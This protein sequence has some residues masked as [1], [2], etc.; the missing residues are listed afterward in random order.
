MNTWAIG[1]SRTS[2]KDVLQKELFGTANAKMSDEL[3]TGTIPRDDIHFETLVRDG[4]VIISAKIKWYQDDG[5]W[6]GEYSTLTFKSTEQ[7]LAT[8]MGTA[9]DFILLDEEAPRGSL[10]IFSQCLTRCG[11]TN[12]RVL[13]TA[14]PENK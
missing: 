11:T 3:G 7:G 6:S 8:L 13:I 2:T 14:T 1:I 12:G 10:E 9:M 5:E 4:D